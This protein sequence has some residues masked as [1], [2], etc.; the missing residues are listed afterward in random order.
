M[1]P[2]K[3]DLHGCQFVV[4]IDNAESVLGKFVLYY[5]VW[6][7]EG[8]IFMLNKSFAPIKIKAKCNK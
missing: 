4:V 6:K 5:T 1:I 7:A 2:L 8:F 3:D